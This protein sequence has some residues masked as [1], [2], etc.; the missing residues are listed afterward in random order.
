MNY[1][2]D[3]TFIFIYIKFSLS[4]DGNLLEFMMVM[5]FYTVFYVFN[6]KPFF[7]SLTFFYLTH[8]FYSNNHKF[9]IKGITN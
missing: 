9:Y 4:V 7:T 6:V 3:K 8:K 2:H 1:S 5:F